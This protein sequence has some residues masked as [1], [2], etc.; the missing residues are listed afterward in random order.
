MNKESQPPFLVYVMWH[1]DSQDSKVAADSIRNHFQS[2][3]FLHAAAGRSIEVVYFDELNPR[4]NS[5]ELAWDAPCPVAIVVLLDR[6]VADN[7]KWV[8]Y[9]RVIGNRTGMEDFQKRMFP[10][11]IESSVLDSVLIDQ[12]AIRWDQWAGTAQTRSA[13]LMRTL[14]YE[15][16]KTLQQRLHQE[17]D[18]QRRWK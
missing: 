5:F 3:R 8:E 6:Q 17:T 10:V 4:A 14:T 7:P 2:P 1:P 12:Q 15:F 13:R 18:P 11:S 16:T 9:V